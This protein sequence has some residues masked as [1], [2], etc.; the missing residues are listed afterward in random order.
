[1]ISYGFDDDDNGLQTREN[2][3]LTIPALQSMHPD[4]ASTAKSDLAVELRNIRR[5]FAGAVSAIDGIDL[6]ITV[7]EFVAILGPSGCGKTTL[8]RIIAGLDRADSGSLQIGHGRDTRKKIAYVFQDAHLLPWR[9]ALRNVALPL[10]LM[11]MRRAERLDAAADA[12]AQ[13]GLSDAHALYPAQLSGGMRMRVSLARALVT[14]PSLLLLDE[15][16]AAL[17][18]LTR[19]QLDEQLHQ[20][21]H[22]RRMTVIF[23]THSIVEATFLA[24]RAL[25][26]TPRPARI[27]LDH[28]IALPEQRAP[29][30]RTE[31]QFAREL[32]VQ[33]EAL[34][35]GQENRR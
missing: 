24:Q 31:P 7:G 2:Q 17:D 29:V 30:L 19:N 28:R 1:V 10:E 6:R 5:V 27:V 11:G 33:F 16:F 21:W 26:L 34:E 23:V 3:I 13:V 35:Q 14:N 25:V 12:I 8:L 22:R 15:P 4:L 9:D 32:R 20:L 18:E